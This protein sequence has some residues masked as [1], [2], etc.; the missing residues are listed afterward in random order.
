MVS[1]NLYISL[2][3]MLIVVNEE[4]F[5][6]ICMIYNLGENTRSYLVCHVLNQLV[7]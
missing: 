1:D 6:E 2:E 7:G 5:D 3:P 4:I